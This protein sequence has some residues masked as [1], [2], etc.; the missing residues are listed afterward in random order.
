[1]W[2]DRYRRPG[3]LY[4]TDPNDF[5]AAMAPH[6]PPG[7]VL[8][9]GEGEGRNAVYLAELG[10]DVLAVDASGVGMEKA[11]RLAASRGVRIRTRTLDLSD[12]N[13]EPGAWEGIVSI[14]CHLP[15]PLRR[16]VHREVVAGLRPGG[17]FILEAYTPRQPA[18]GTGG[19]STPDLLMCLP[20]LKRELRGLDFRVAR[21]I[22][23]VVHEG[24]HHTGLGHVVQVAA[25][26]CRGT[27]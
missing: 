11:A 23:R 27:G 17:L 9:L 13:I 14:F 18:Y 4:G 3:Y 6:I 7:R 20:D 10:Y 5:L 12:F 21:E 2:N 19:P 1:M 25:A 8:S 24:S 15:P 26:A 16:R 22:E